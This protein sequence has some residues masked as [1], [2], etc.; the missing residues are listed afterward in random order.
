MLNFSFHSFKEAKWKIHGIKSTLRKKFKKIACPSFKSPLQ[1][2]TLGF[3]IYLNNR[4]ENCCEH[5]CLKNAILILIHQLRKIIKII[6]FRKKLKF[7]YACPSALCV[8]HAHIV[9]FEKYTFKIN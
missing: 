3:S 1:N 9:F 5:M 7:Q 8:D 2:G 6:F 4:K